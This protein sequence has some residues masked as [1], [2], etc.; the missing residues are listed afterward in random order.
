MSQCNRLPHPVHLSGT[1][2]YHAEGACRP[3]AVQAD[4]IP[5]LGCEYSDNQ[6]DSVNGIQNLGKPAQG[7]CALEQ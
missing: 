4:K 6:C 2:V 3:V 7:G 5:P 1:A